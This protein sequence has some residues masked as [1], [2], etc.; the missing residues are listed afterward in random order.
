MAPT[1]ALISLLL[2]TAAAAESPVGPAPIIDMHLHSFGF[3]DY[4]LPVPPNEVTGRS[5]AYRSDREAMA[6][7][8]AAMRAAGIVR[9]VVSG[10][11]EDVKRWRAALGDRALGAAYAGPR[12]PLPPLADLRRLVQ[13]G[14]IAA[15]GELGLQYLGISPDSPEMDPYWLL[16]QEFDLPVGIHTGLGDVGTPYG[17][18]PRFRARLGN[19]LLLEDVLVRFPKLRIYLM[20]GGYP[21][22]Q[23]T[24]ALLS[25]YPQVYLDIAVIN[26]AIPRAEFHAYLRG[27]I[28]AGFADRIM[29]GSDQMVWPESIGLAVAGVESA[30]FLTSAQKRAIFYGNAARF[31]RLTE[32]EIRADHPGGQ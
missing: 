10:P 8:L 20:H 27:L 16:A 13:A 23:E 1:A 21:F 15:L 7:S 12:D 18:C 14:E 28:D 30:P 11:L 9:A 26:W 19:P 17:C 31:L 32:A 29:F 4:G 6:A 24:K 22:L 25:I 3:D 2:L 5:P